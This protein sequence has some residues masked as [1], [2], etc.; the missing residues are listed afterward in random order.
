[1][2]I[3]A[4]QLDL[5]SLLIGFILTAVAWWLVFGTSSQAQGPATT[6]EIQVG[7]GG[8]Y[9]LKTNGAVYFRTKQQCASRC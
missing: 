3:F 8:V 6:Q 4:W 7:D 1:M 2:K 5:R 9:I